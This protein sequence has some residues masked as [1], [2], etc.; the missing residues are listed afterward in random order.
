[1]AQQRLTVE[2]LTN[3]A[4]P[5]LHLN[6]YEY[7]DTVE[8]ELYSGGN[9]FNVPSGSTFWFNGLKPDGRA[10]SYSE[11]ITYSSNIVTITL[12]E[13]MTAVGGQHEAELVIF[14][15]DTRRS[16]INII[17]DVEPAPF[18][19][20]TLISETDIPAII[21]AGRAAANAAAASEANAAASEAAAATSAANAHLDA[22]TAHSDATNAHIDATN[23]HTDADR[24]QSYAVGTNGSVRPGDATDNAQ[25]YYTQTHS[26]AQ[27]A[28]TYLTLV[29]AY[30]DFLIPSFYVDL[31]TMTLYQ[32]EGSVNDFTFYLTDGY[33]YYEYTK[34]SSIIHIDSADNYTFTDTGAGDIA[35]TQN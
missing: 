23:A 25:Y 7:G 35:I 34:G 28:H 5:V 22:V 9:V 12:Y 31:E 15:N 29:E 13:Q 14:Q 3:V 27:S 8:L 18:Y 26:D 16:T 32:D 10:Y 30:S 4:K 20:D 11:G 1:M 24:A 6:Q 2:M 33:L 17:M 21:D 19:D